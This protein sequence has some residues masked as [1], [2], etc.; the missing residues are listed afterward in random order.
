MTRVRVVLAL[1]LLLFATSANAMDPISLIA[2]AI[3]MLEAAA[4]TVVLGFNA[5]YVVATAIVAAG[6]SAM[7]SR[8]RRKAR[9]AYNATLSDRT[10]TVRGASEPRRMVLGRQRV[11][12]VVAFIGSTGANKEQLV[13]VIALAGHECD[14]IERYYFNDVPVDVV[15]EYVQTAPYARVDTLS[16]NETFVGNGITTTFTISRTPLDGS[17]AAAQQTG[18]GEGGESVVFPVSG[19]SGAVVTLGT[20]PSGNFVIS[21]QYQKTTSY[22]RVRSF[23]GG[24]GQ[25]VDAVVNSL[26]PDEWDASHPL[27]GCAGIAVFLTYNEDVYQTDTQVSVVMRGAKCYDP[28]KD[29][30]IGGSGP[31]RVNDPSTWEWTESPPLLI[32]YAAMSPLCGRQPASAIRW[33]DVATAANVCDQQVDYSTW[34][35]ASDEDGVLLTDE[36]GIQLLI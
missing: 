10:M 18:S 23:L 21:Y 6:L 33:S 24:P 20:A 27:S 9:D 36:S 7:A 15:D 32:G 11:G 28:R 8:A 22:A 17:V 26:F 35:L 19:V 14:G 16:A 34:G 30:S 31:H 3:F 2:N 13:M 29:S 1:A 5:T 25:T 4:G 12:G